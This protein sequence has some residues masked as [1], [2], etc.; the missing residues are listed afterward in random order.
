MRLPSRF[1]HRLAGAAALACAAALTPA[2]AI[3]AA[4]APAAGPPKCATSGLVIWLTQDDAAAGSAFFT[5]NFT[6]LSGHT[7]TLGGHPGVSAV[8][9]GG[10]KLGSPADWVPSAAHSVTLA[11]SATGYALLQYS[12]VITGGGGPKPCKPVTAAGLRVY[13]PGQTAA[14]T[15]PIPLTA[16]TTSGLVYMTVRPLQKTPPPS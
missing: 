2:A 13:P 6:N 14:K 3:A 16:C 15:V 1:S 8:S 9:L 5:L 7:C 11:N 4:P 12:D 10:R